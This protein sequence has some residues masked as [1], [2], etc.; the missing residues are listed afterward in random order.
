MHTPQKEKVAQSC[1]TI[2]NPMDYT[3]HGILQARIL[4]WVAIPFSRRSSQTRDQTQVSLISGGFFT[5][6]AT[7]EEP[8]KCAPNPTAEI[9]LLIP[10]H[11]LYLH[12]VLLEVI[13]GFGLVACSCILPEEFRFNMGALGSW[14]EFWKGDELDMCPPASPISLLPKRD[15]QRASH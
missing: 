11:T 5:S 6:W 2:C 3:V 1:L 12:E 15:L 7:R 10:V 13:P 4:D 8:Q 9:P 14:Q